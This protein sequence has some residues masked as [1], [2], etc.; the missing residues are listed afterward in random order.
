MNYTEVFNSVKAE[1]YS[2]E[3]AIL[4]TMMVG[5]HVTKIVK[6]KHITKRV[7]FEGELEGQFK[8]VFWEHR[9]EVIKEAISVWR[10]LHDYETRK[11]LDGL[12]GCVAKTIRQLIEEKN[13][14]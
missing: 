11:T 9:P 8:E 1:K 14:P 12:G 7:S 3:V 2:D 5:F 13:S 6:P 10:V 4:V